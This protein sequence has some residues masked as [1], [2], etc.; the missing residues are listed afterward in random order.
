MN[1]TPYTSDSHILA[2]KEVRKLFRYLI[3]NREIDLHPDDT[4]KEGMGTPALTADEAALF[5]RLIQEGFAVCQEK[6][7]NIYEF[8]YEEMQNFLNL[9]NR[10]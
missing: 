2:P 5:N 1:T 6:G 7:A 3:Q 8:G 9:K 4:L 10:K